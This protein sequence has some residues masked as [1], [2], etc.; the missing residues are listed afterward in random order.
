MGYPPFKTGWTLCCSPHGNMGLF[1]A[2][3]AT[4]RYDK[5]V[6]RVNLL[7]NR[8]SPWMD[9][10]SFL[11]Y[12]G[13]VV[14]KNKEA[15]EVF[16][17]MPLWVRKQAVKCRVLKG[18][19]SST[20]YQ[21]EEVNPKWFD[22]YLHIGELAKGDVV[23]IRF[24]VEERTEVWTAPPQAPN[25]LPIPGG[26]KHIV[27]F[28]GN[29]VVEI[30]PPLFPDTQVYRRRSAKYK[31]TKVPMKKVTRYITRQVLQW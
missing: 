20:G 14:L 7:L 4:L 31:S 15:K 19:V 17:R 21:M 12:E 11:P 10:E 16:V 24:P 30:D 18:N 9:I 3:E 1:Y 27:Q 26:K 28:R 25:C 6:A 23:T 13:K 2:W 22:N 8:A 5:G 29:T